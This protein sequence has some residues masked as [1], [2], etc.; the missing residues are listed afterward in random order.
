MAK[1]PLRITATRHPKLI[2]IDARAWMARLSARDGRRVTL[3]DVRPG[4]SRPSP[5]SASISSG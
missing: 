5:I 4:M 1:A 3:G 2:Q